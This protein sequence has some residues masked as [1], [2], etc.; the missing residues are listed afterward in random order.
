MKNKISLEVIATFKNHN[1]DIVKD[2]AVSKAP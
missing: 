1:Q 2:F